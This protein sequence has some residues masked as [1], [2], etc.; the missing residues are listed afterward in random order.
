M[1]FTVSRLDRQA[2]CF[3]DGSHSSRSFQVCKQMYADGHLAARAVA[4]GATRAVAALEKTSEEG[5]ICFYFQV[6]ERHNNIEGAS[7]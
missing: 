6:F 1:W 3:L 5:W 7:L 2:E 4:M